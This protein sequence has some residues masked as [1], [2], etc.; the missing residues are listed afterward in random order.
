MTGIA[1]LFILVGQPGLAAPV[2]PFA[3]GADVSWLPQMEAQGV[4]FYDDNGVRKDCLQ[5]LKEHGINAIRLRVWVNPSADKCSGHCS[6]DETVAMAKR[7]SDS[8]FRVMIDFHYSDSWAD[9]GKQTKPAA[10]TNHST[11]QLAT[12]VYNHTTEVLKAVIAAGVHPEWVQVGNETNDGILWENG[13]VSVTGDFTDF[14]SLINSGYNAVK[15]VDSSIKV[16]IHIANGYDNNLFRWMFDGLTGSGAR[17]DIIGMSSYPSTGNWVARDSLVL[18]NCNDM[19]SRYG[20]EVMISETGMD[21]SSTTRQMITDLIGKVASTQNGRGLGVFIWEPECYNWCSYALGAWNSNGRPGVA[22]DAFLTPVGTTG[23]ITTVSSDGIGVTCRIG[24]TML[25]SFKIS[26]EGPF[27][28]SV[29]DCFG[30][31][32]ARIVEKSML[33]GTYSVRW[34]VCGYRGGVYF[35]RMRQPDGTGEVR[36]LMLVR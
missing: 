33:P 36:K 23:G 11:V 35:L 26:E 29:F 2:I 31:S 13:R 30:K 19:V 8:G 21:A 7:A 17:Y 1:T 34:N 22:M 15:A 18:A 24:T 32:V 4:A 6:K 10:W 27:S 12:D 20:K 3:R 16:I 28:L 5:I 9:P 25:V 14:V